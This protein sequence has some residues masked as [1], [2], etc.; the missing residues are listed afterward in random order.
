MEQ[1]VS[2]CLA[3][4]CRERIGSLIPHVPGGPSNRVPLEVPLEGSARDCA[5]IVI[6]HTDELVWHRSAVQG[7]ESTEVVRL[8]PVP[9]TEAGAVVSNELHE[10]IVSYLS[11]LAYDLDLESMLTDQGEIRD[12]FYGLVDLLKCRVSDGV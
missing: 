10:E 5:H 12:R 3:Y 1:N 9:H 2:D 7:V 11:R 8:Y 6:R 4:Q